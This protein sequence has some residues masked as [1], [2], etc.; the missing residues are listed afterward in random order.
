MVQKGTARAR[1]LARRPGR[2]R[3]WSKKMQDQKRATEEATQG[4]GVTVTQT[5]NNELKLDIPSDISFDTGKADIK[6]QM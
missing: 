3:I 1:R 5:P 2:R 4:T 6:P